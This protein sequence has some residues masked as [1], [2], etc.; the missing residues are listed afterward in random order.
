MTEQRRTIARVLNA[1][2]DHPDVEELY[3]RC[4]K[5]DSR[6]LGQRVSSSQRQQTTRMTMFTSHSRT[7]SL[8]LFV[9]RWFGVPWYSLLKVQ[10]SPFT[11][12]GETEASLFTATPE[13]PGCSGKQENLWHLFQ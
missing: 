10:P 11:R 7:L 4:A 6:I 1:A 5:I 13:S 9:F 8:R 3:R 2:E 12:S